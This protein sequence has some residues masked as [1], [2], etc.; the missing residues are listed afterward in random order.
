MHAHETHRHRGVGAR[1]KGDARREKLLLAHLHVRDV[2]MHAGEGEQ[3]RTPA[4][5][6]SV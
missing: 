5:S 1:G 3:K 2:Q 6:R 4:H